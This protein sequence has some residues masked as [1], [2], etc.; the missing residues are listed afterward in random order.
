MEQGRLKSRLS[1]L[2]VKLL[3]ARKRESER[4]RN[5]TGIPVMNDKLY[6]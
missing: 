4:E 5:V 1:H 2:S 6:I 3:R